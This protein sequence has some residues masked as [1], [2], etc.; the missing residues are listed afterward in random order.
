M[1]LLRM[2]MR[3]HPFL[4]ILLT[5]ASKS[6]FPEH[7]GSTTCLCRLPRA[8]A[9]ARLCALRGALLP[10]APSKVGTQLLRKSQNQNSTLCQVQ[11][12]GTSEEAADQQGLLPLQRV[13][14]LSLPVWRKNRTCPCAA[15]QSAALRSCPWFPHWRAAP[16]L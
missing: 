5:M 8:P 4:L 6:S 12:L 13:S 11:Q 10:P 2:C 15:G 7:N 1:L 14:I 9:L 3:I 16:G